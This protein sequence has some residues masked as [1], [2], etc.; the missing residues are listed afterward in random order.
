[1]RTDVQEAL[2]LLVLLASCLAGGT[3]PQEQVQESQRALSTRESQSNAAAL[4]PLDVPPVKILAAHK[5]GHTIEQAKTPNDAK[6]VI[7][8]AKPAAN[9]PRGIHLPDAGQGA[10]LK[11][12]VQ[13][14]TKVILVTEI[15]DPPPITVGTASVLSAR[16]EPRRAIFTT[17]SK[18]TLPNHR[19]SRH[20]KPPATIVPGRK[21]LDHV[22]NKTTAAPRPTRI[23]DATVP[24]GSVVTITRAAPIS[25]SHRQESEE[26]HENQ[27]DQDDQEDQQDQQENKR[28]ETGSNDEST[29]TRSLRKNVRPTVEGRRRRNNLR[30]FNLNEYRSRLNTTFVVPQGRFF[31]QRA[32]KSQQAHFQSLLCLIMTIAVP[33]FVWLI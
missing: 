24:R 30:P 3:F 25:S 11:D 27:D 23:R 1:M 20:N 31:R 16:S 10:P 14:V 26:D 28:K 18:V 33:I 15:V 5:H 12:D 19:Q 22:P 32:N 2:T 21:P 17:S 4:V 7:L 13:T 6:P 8:V 9:P 29:T